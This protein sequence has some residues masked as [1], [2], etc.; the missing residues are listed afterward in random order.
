MFKLIAAMGRLVV[1]MYVRDSDR[2]ERKATAQE[3]K[4]DALVAEAASLVT[5]AKAK[6]ADSRETMRQS[7]EIEKKADKLKAIL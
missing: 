4:A 1:R 5:Q 7:I 6:A 3:A 2:L